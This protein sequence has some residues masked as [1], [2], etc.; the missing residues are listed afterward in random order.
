MTTEK[1]IDDCSDAELNIRLCLWMGWRRS[2]EVLGGLHEWFDPAGSFRGRYYRPETPPLPNYV[3]GHGSLDLMA[4]A[5]ARLTPDQW[6]RYYEDLEVLTR[7]EMPDWFPN[8]RDLNPSIVIDVC[9]VHASA[10]QRA[11]A[12]LKTVEAQP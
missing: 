9:L 6:L 8:W 10:R 12:L 11:I 4:L 1:Q 2:E 5:E 7:R 3:T